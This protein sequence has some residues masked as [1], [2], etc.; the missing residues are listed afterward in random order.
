MAGHRAAATRDHHTILQAKEICPECQID[1]PNLAEESVAGDV[2]CTDC[3]LV[4]QNRMIDER[5][6]WRT[7]SNDDVGSSNPSRVGETMTNDDDLHQ[8]SHLHT[9]IANSGRSSTKLS[10]GLERAQAR[11][12]HEPRAF[13]LRHASAEIEECCDG[14]R[15][16]VSHV[17]C[18]KQLYRHAL[19]LGWL[20]RHARRTSISVCIAVVCSRVFN[21]SRSL[22]E[23]RRTLDVERKLFGQ[24]HSPI[25][26][27]A[28]EG[29]NNVSM[30]E[31]EDA[32]ITKTTIGVCERI[33]DRLDFQRPFEVIKVATSIIHIAM[34]TLGGK[35]PKTIA[36]ACVLMACQLLQYER[37]TKEIS[38]AGNCGL[39]AI[40]KAYEKIWLEREE[41]VGCSP[42]CVERGLRS[43]IIEARPWQR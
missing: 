13:S 3:G 29:S 12:I 20:H 28:Q 18:V 10:H 40:K 42:E 32:P 2:V 25:P 36:A 22:D 15:L 39:A 6:E 27:P 7:F 35:P 41:I 11:S 21:K 26:G 4:L 23:I 8:G 33:C 5:A 31:A 43:D 37:S 38:A 17:R 14:L 19:D 24:Y 34:D 1:P 30:E 16:D 9:T